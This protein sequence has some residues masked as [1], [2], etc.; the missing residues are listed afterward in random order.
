MLFRSGLEAVGQGLDL[1]DLD[2]AD[3]VLA[4]GVDA[5]GENLARVRGHGDADAPN[6]E[7][8]AFVLLARASPAVAASARVTALVSAAVDHALPDGGRTALVE[9]ALA[10]A[11]VEPDEVAMLWLAG[12]GSAG[13]S[14]PLP[15]SLFRI[16]CGGANGALALVA[17]LDSVSRSHAPALA[18][19]LPATGV[20]R[21]LVLTPA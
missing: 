14:T 20:Q 19:D 17:A 4:G 6:G 12:D 10:E 7:G 16:G 9:R 11:G 2:R 1:L 5:L 3:C 15:T 21:V 13:L 18:A 8:A